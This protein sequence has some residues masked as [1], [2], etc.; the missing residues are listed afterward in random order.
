M[1][2][3]EQY[4]ARADTPMTGSPVGVVMVKVIE[5]HPGISFEDARRQAHDLLSKA[6]KS[7]RYQ[8]PRVRSRE[9]QAA[10]AERLKN[11]FR[12]VPAVV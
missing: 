11:V 7:R 2:T 5:K 3:T 8:T 9:E 6:A 4:F 1:E 10:D 12:S